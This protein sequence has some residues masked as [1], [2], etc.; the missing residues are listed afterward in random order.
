MNLRMSILG[1][2]VVPL[3][4]CVPVCAAGADRVTTT[5]YVGRHFEVRDH[6]QPVKHVF[7]GDT[8]AIALDQIKI[9]DEAASSGKLNQQDKELDA[10]AP[11]R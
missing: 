5:V 1:L 4:A 10:I 6:D 8:H 3:T 9:M 2:A 11:R 7:Q